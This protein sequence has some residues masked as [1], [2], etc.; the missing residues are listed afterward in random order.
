[1][2]AD[3]IGDGLPVS[4]IPSRRSSLIPKNGE[5]DGAEMTPGDVFNA[6]RRHGLAKVCRQTV[7]YHGFP[8]WISEI[9]RL[10]HR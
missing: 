5:N 2:R 9:P 3:T 10:G 6:G 4:V 1:M 8:A 7:S